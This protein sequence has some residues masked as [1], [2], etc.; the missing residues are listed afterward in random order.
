MSL[1]R[2]SPSMAVALLALFVALGGSA[3]AAFV[4]SS[5]SQVGPNTIAGG[6]AP[7]GAHSNIIAGSVA[8]ADIKPNS[9]GSG[10]ILDGSLTGAD[11]L[12]NTITGVQ[13]NEG[14]LAKVPSAAT[15]DDAA[16][17]GSQPPAFYTAHCAAGQLDVAITCADTTPRGPNPWLAAARD[18]VQRGEALPTLSE[19]LALGLRQGDGIW[20]DVS[21][22]DGGITKAWKEQ[23]T[24]GV[25]DLVAIDAQSGIGYF[26]VVPKEG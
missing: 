6:N 16:K 9:I 18:C 19:A 14:S 15:A 1:R 21:W 23:L 24:G 11:L 7:A 5:N 8:A 3:M 13:V 26:C 17:L 22:T 12:N 4:V 10:R 25:P 20:T 2:L